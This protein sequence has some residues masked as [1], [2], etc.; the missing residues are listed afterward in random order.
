MQRAARVSESTAEGRKAVFDRAYSDWFVES[1][2]EVG[3]VVK[4]KG[5]WQPQRW[6]TQRGTLD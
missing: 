1:E 2:V 5:A 3:H 6:R 4:R